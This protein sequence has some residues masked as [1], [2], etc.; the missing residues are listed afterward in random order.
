[1]MVFGGQDG[2]TLA[3]DME[4]GVKLWEHDA[5]ESVFATPAATPEDNIFIVAK[6]HIEVL[7]QVSYNFV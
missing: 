2:K 6:G 4:T 3:Y 5:G 7:R 1:M